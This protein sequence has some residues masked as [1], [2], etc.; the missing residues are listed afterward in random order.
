MTILI[1]GSTKG[2]GL[3]LALAL[4]KAGKTV[5]FTGRNPELLAE[6]TSSLPNAKSLVLD[7]N[8]FDSNVLLS[9]LASLNIPPIS[10]I[11][12]NAGIFNKGWT[13]E[14]FDATLSTNTHGPIKLIQTLLPILNNA[15]IINITASQLGQISMLPPSYQTR[16]NNIS[17]IQDIAS[18]DFDEN[19]EIMK[20]RSSSAYVLSKVLLNKA[21]ELFSQDPLLNTNKIVSVCPGWCK[22]DL[23]KAF[24]A[25]P[26]EISE[27]VNSISYLIDNDFIN[28]QLYLDGK[29]Y[30]EPKPVSSA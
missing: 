25:A 9:Q 18:I 19:D 24:G 12:N 1:T 14:N 20:K 28:G 17:T 13:K 4:V 16:V 3:A 2:L 21:T 8:S 5:I 11:I 29:L 7:I 15:K 23:G 27:G 26:R 22:T 30:P 6:I 10:V